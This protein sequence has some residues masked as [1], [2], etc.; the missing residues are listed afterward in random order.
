MPIF[1]YFYNCIVI[2]MYDGFSESS[3]SCQFHCVVRRV[4]KFLCSVG[5]LLLLTITRLSL[6]FYSFES[7]TPASTDG[8]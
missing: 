2:A 1:K 4:V 5:F 7:F 6:L 8:F 3:V